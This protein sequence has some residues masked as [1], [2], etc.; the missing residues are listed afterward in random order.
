MEAENHPKYPVFVLCGSDPKRRKLLHVLDPEEKYKSKA[1]IPLLGKRV[2][3]WQLEAL[4]E[5]PYVEDLY[6]IGLSKEDAA[7]DYPVHYVP[8][9]TTAEFPEKLM[10]GLAYLDRLG[11]HPDQVVISTSD[12]PAIRLEHINDFFVQLTKYSDYDFVLAVVPEESIADV[13]PLFG[14]VFARFR[15]HEVTPGEMY[16]LSPKAICATPAKKE[17]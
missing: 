12:A 2:M 4:K 7:F 10:D 8:S 13:F 14:R 16:A 15:D 6:L 17:K 1:L 3:D 11:I 9:E 5:S